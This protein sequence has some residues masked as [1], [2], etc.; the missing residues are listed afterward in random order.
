MLLPTCQYFHLKNWRVMLMLD[1]HREP[2]EGR[3][4][5][6][7]DNCNGYVYREDDNCYGDEYYDFD[8]FFVCTNC[9]D[10]YLKEHKRRLQ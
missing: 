10:E 5:I 9:I 3:D 1:L 6:L 4:F 2:D 8:G 7:C